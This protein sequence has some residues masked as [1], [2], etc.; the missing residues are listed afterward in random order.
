MRNA[1]LELDD[2]ITCDMTTSSEYETSEYENVKN[3]Y[4]KK[5]S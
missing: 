5:Y 2:I 1:A 4:S 3:I